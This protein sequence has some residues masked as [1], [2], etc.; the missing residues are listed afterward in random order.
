MLRKM[1][2]GKGL[3]PLYTPGGTQDSREGK[4]ISAED[5]ADSRTGR[6]GHKLI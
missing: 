1:Q 6:D 2:A 4:A 3:L 5:K